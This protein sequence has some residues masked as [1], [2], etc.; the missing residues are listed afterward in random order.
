MRKVRVSVPPRSLGMRVLGGRRLPLGVPVPRWELGGRRQWGVT[1][2]PGLL[3]VPQ[4][5]YLASRPSRKW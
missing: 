4:R 3:M 1:D 5:G 2:R